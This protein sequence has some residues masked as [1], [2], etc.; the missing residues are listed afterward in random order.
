MDLEGF[1]SIDADSL[2]GVSTVSSGHATAEQALEYLDATW[3]TMLSRRGR[4]MDLIC[5]YACTEPFII[6]GRF[7]CDRV[8]FYHRIFFSN[9]TS[10]HLVY[11]SNRELIAHA[12]CLSV[13]TSHSRYC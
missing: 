6:D 4:W 8:T 5:D 13:S 10:L 11:H 1:E 9:A 12:S 2:N 7:A 3:Y